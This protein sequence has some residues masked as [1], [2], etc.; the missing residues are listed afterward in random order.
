MS[1]GYVRRYVEKNQLQRVPR[2]TFELADKKADSLFRDFHANGNEG[3]VTVA[4]ARHLTACPT[5]DKYR[6]RVDLIVTSPPYLD[7]VNYAKQNW[8][9]NWFFDEHG[10]Y[11]SVADLDD[12]L[13]LQDWML[14]AEQSVDQMKAML[15]TDGV[16][17]MVIGDVARS[18]GAISLARSFMQRLIYNKTFNYVG[19]LNDRIQSETKT[20]RIW[21]ETKGRATN[22]DRIV[23][24]SDKTPEFRYE[25]LAEALFG[26]SSVEFGAVT[27]DELQEQARQF[28]Q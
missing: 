11:G 23:V 7:I 4:N 3:V 16:I 28:A 8:I 24:L 14:F 9:R 26:D 6:G 19:C 21:K 15:R 5:L 18:G 17:A 1:P 25:R 22:I 2:N 10:G 13:L 27:A 20:T 12:D